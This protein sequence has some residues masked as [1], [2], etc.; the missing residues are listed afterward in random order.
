MLLRRL[1][2]LAIDDA[3]PE[4]RGLPPESAAAA[5]RLSGIGEAF[6]FG[7][8]GA[9]AGPRAADLVAA[10]DDGV[11][12]GWRGFAHEGAGFGLAVRDALLPV[13]PGRR[14]RL[15]EYATGP[16]IRFA[17]AAMAGA[18]WSLRHLPR[19][20][21]RTLPR[22]D[23]LLRWLPFDG[24]GFHHAFFAWRATV[25][26][27]RVPR[28]LRGYASRAFDQGVGRCLWFGH[29]MASE[30]IGETIGRFPAAR[31]GDLWSGVG[32]AA[33]FAGGG[34]AGSLHALSRVAGVSHRPGLAQGAAFAAFLRHETEENTGWTDD[35]CSVLCGRSAA[36]A[37]ALVVRVRAELP[38]A[39]D[40]GAPEPV[41]EKW[42]RGTRTALAPPG[43]AGRN[44]A[45]A[46]SGIDLPG[47][48]D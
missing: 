47:G 37:A 4:R 16:A 34:A 6:L 28:H 2:G 43:E 22:A 44:S 35:A 17:R 40:A 42:R 27:R 3:R 48:I 5:E 11:P 24:Y 13:L 8:H 10:I 7:Y 36:A 12:F 21:G 32:L 33:S 15:I 26:E 18:G 29:G 1:F 19:W 23:P 41:Y 9:L 14:A 31:R 45:L 25:E 30:R 20:M 38:A 39:D 46:P